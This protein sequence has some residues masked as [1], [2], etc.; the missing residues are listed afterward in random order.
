MVS[1]KPI[2]PLV[3]GARCVPTR[4]L[5]FKSKREL[6]FWVAKKG[7]PTYS[8]KSFESDPIDL[9]GCASRTIGAQK[10]QV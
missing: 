5:A 8:A 2:L 9:V 3:Y 7:N 1:K 4:L 6:Y 10:T